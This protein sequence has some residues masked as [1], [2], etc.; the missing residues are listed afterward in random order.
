M[1]VLQNHLL[2]FGVSKEKIQSQLHIYNK[3]FFTT[4]D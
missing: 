1:L 2:F 3:I 4:S